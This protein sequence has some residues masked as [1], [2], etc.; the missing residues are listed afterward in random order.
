M[1]EASVML[2]GLDWLRIKDALTVQEAQPRGE[3]RLLRVVE[4]YQMPNVSDKVARIIDELYRLRKLGC[5]E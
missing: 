4:Y 5:L 3:D 2:V 1:E